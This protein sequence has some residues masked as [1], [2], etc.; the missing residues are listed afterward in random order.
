MLWP[1]IRKSHKVS[2][3]KTDIV[4][5]GELNVDLILT[6][7]PSLPEMGVCKLSKDM[8]FTLGSASAIFASNIARLGLGVA[9][10]GKLGNDEFGD[11]ILNSLKRRNVATEWIIRDGN[12]KTGICVVLSFPDN[13][14][15]ASYAGVRE[16]LTLS[17]INMEYVSSA[18]HLHLSSYYL[19]TGMLDGCAGLFRQAKK[20]GLTTSLDPDSDPKGQWDESIY[21]VLKYV[22]VFLPNEREALHITKCDSIEA[23][24]DQLSTVVD[25]AVIKAGERG[26]WVK[27]G[28]KNYHADSFKIDVVDTTGAGDSFNSGFIYQYYRGAPIEDCMLWGSACAALSTTKSGGTTAFPDQQELKRFLSARKSDIDHLIESKDDNI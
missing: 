6:G 5:V 2:T 21:E 15:M 13:Y 10:I 28:G 22:D 8:N 3:K 18:R 16:L 7:L 20:M 24:L 26:A 27:K 9:F 1:L 17:D 14:A 25:V 19:Q 12:A 23:A 11:F 4:V